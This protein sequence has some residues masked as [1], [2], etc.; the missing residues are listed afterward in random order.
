M[1]FRMICL[2]AALFAFF[3]G[4]VA[5]TRPP[6]KINFRP[7][8]LEKQRQLAP[9]AQALASQGFSIKMASADAGII[10]TE[11]RDFTIILGASVGLPARDSVQVT[12][13]EKGTTVRYSAQCNYGAAMQDFNA[14]S[15]GRWLGPLQTGSTEWAPC[16]NRGDMIEEELQERHQAAIR[17]IQAAPAKTAIAQHPSKSDEPTTDGPC[18]KCPEECGEEK[19]SCNSGDV[20]ACYRLGACLCR[21]KLTAGG[22][23]EAPEELAD[24]VARNSEKAK[25]N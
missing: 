15:A 22:C 3:A 14:S 11:W 8:L 23:G 19:A 24:C 5:T 1:S 17:A 2:C 4:C 6:Q 13:S 25:N 16:D 20:Q 7:A 18:Q 21:C 9:I 10:N 12:N